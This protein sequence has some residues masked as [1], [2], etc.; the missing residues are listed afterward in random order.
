[1]QFVNLCLVLLDV[2][3][4]K[5]AGA[6][7]CSEHPAAKVVCICRHQSASGLHAEVVREVNLNAA[8]AAAIVGSGDVALNIAGDVF[9][10]LFGHLCS[11]LLVQLALQQ[12]VAGAKYVRCRRVHYSQLVALRLALGSVC[13]QLF[14][15]YTLG[16]LAGIA[17]VAS[18]PVVLDNGPAI[19]LDW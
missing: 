9:K 4:C 18:L 8:A 17:P 13:L 12:R 10:L 2:V 19:G 5:I 3:R 11:L 15:D 1:M 6:L 16:M 14:I 7:D